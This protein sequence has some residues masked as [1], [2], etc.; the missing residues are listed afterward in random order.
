MLPHSH[1]IDF[2]LHYL[3]FSKI[4]LIENFGTLAKMCSFA[5]EIFE[6]RK[7]L[8]HSEFL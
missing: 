2:L 8:K 5:S 1:N 7:K 6:K 3:P 4:F